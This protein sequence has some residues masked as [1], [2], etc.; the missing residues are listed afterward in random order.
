MQARSTASV[1][2]ILKATVQVLVRVGKEKLTT[3]KVAQRAGVS[4]GTLYQYFPNKAAL[5]RAAL[6]L[7][8]EAI[9]FEVEQVC[10]AQRG[11]PVEQMAEALAKAF[12]AVKMRDPKTSRALYAVGSDLEGAKIVS[13]GFAR[14]NGAIVAMLETAPEPLAQELGLMATVL[15]STISGVKRQLLESQIPEAE[16]PSLQR[17]LVRA[18]RGYVRACVAQDAVLA[19]QA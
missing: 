8:V 7:H 2:A 14:V 10:V 11:Q 19:P 9:I 3:T 6:V 1:D 5:L 17:E 13:K 18:V 15:Q 4:V 16:F 12:L